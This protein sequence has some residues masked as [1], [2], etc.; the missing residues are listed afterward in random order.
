MEPRAVSPGQGPGCP[1]EEAGQDHRQQMILNQEF[2]QL[3]KFVV[4][5]QIQGQA[6]S[7]SAG[8]DQTQWVQLGS[9][10]LSRFVVTKWGQGHQP[11]GQ[12]QDQWGPWPWSC[13]GRDWGSSRACG[14]WLG[15]TTGE[16]FELWGP[17]Q[18][19]SRVLSP[20]HVMWAIQ[21]A[22][23]MLRILPCDVW[24]LPTDKI[25]IPELSCSLQKVLE[26]Y[27]SC[28][29]F[30]SDI[31]LPFK[32][33]LLCQWKKSG[34]WKSVTCRDRCIILHMPR[35]QNLRKSSQGCLFTKVS[36]QQQLKKKKRQVLALS[37]TFYL[38]HIEQA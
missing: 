31:L 1:S 32:P 14:Q 6:G 30:K 37:E 35:T 33:K 15:K 19:Q 28:I 36:L 23:E 21:K 24:R 8:Q 34:K 13:P 27:H 5:R 4:K 9:W 25:V 2:R 26:F 20:T 29:L 22:L 17:W 12:A 16:V 3:D 11:M 7:L 18:L 38:F 10:P